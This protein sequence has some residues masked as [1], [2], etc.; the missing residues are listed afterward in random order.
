VETVNALDSVLSI[1]VVDGVVAVTRT[2]VCTVPE[3]TTVC[4]VPSV[5][6]MAESGAT[7]SPPTFVSGKKVTLIPGFGAPLESETLKISVAV[8]LSPVPFNPIVVRGVVLGG[9]GLGGM[10]WIDP[11][12]A[13]D[14]LTG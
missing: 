6:D 1:G 5:P 12:A 7:L 4:T 9:M 13:A 2:T 11:A 8:S 10:N 14:T 3:L